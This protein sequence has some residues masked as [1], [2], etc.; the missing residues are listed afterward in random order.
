MLQK[1]EA[2]NY[3]ILSSYHDLSIFPMIHAVCLQLQPGNVFV[4]AIENTIVIFVIN[5]AGF[6]Y[7]Y[8]ET[9]FTDYS[10]LITFFSAS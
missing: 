1:L 3:H 4:D 7:L 5:K 6:A 10:G 9:S 8:T 2:R